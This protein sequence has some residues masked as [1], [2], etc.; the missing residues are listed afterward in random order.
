MP[1]ALAFRTGEDLDHLDVEE[2][3]RLGEEAG[4]AWLDAFSRGTSGTLRRLPPR[5]A[6]PGALAHLLAGTDELHSVVGHVTQ[7]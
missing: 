5:E 6:I 4:G 3:L 7:L 1:P 2:A